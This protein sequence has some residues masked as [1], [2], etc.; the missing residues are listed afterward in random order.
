VRGERRDRKSAH[1][2]ES[3]RRHRLTLKDIYQFQMLTAGGLLR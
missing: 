3:R 2:H 1:C